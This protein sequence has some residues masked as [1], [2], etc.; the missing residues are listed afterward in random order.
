MPYKNS[1]DQRDYHKRRYANEPLFRS[2]MRERGRKHDKIRNKLPERREF[3]RK[4]IMEVKYN[5]KFSVFAIYSE[6]QPRCSCCGETAI[7]FL[8]ID[9]TAQ[10]GAEHRKILPVNSRTGYG[11]YCW[12]KKNGFPE[13]YGVLCLNCNFS[14]GHFRY[15]PHEWKSV[16]VKSEQAL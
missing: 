5:L 14:L 10:N 15:C 4:V 12:L 11:F 2:R 9:H 8:T 7:E 3:M 6:G 13:G 1:Q 16:N